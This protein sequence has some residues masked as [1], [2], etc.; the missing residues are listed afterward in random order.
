M[1]GSA[2]S[3]DTD[4]CFL[5]GVSLAGKEKHNSNG[6]VHELMVADQEKEGMGFLLKK[7]IVL[8]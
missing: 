2:L 3:R 8:P 6:H 1:P 7:K 5:G 4:P